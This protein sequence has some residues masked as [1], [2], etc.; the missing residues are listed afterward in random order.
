VGYPV[1]LSQLGDVKGKAILDYG[2][3]TGTFS[4]FL[5][6]KGAII[7]GLDVSENM[8]VYSGDTDVSS[9]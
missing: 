4:R 3:G 2:C 5:Q 8:I 6:S 7:T 1:V 9:C